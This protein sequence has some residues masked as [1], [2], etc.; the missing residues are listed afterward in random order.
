MTDLSSMTAPKLKDFFDA[1]LVRALASEMSR[2]DPGFDAAAFIAHGSDGLDRLELSARAWHLAEGLQKSL[3]QPFPR[4]ADVLVASLGPEIPP[5]GNNGLSPLRYMPHVFF[6]QKYGLDDFEAAMRAQYELTKRFSAES[7]IRAF[8]VR[9]PDRTYARLLEWARDENAH[10]RRLVSEGSRPRLPWAPRL[11]AFQIDP[12][13]VIVL[14]EL[15]KD[16]PERYVQRSVANNLNDIGKDHPDLAVELCRQWLAGASPGREW[17]VRHALR[18]LV[19][20]GHRGALQA[21][22]VDGKPEISVTGA[23]LAPRR[24]EIGG[25]LR[26]SFTVTSTAG[27]VQDL[28]VDY[29][30]HFVKAN[31]ETRPKV[32]KLRRM[33]LPPAARVDLSSIVS[34][35]DM[36]TRRHYP[37][38]HRIDV[39]IN[40]VAYPLAEFEVR[41]SPPGSSYSQP[42]R[43]N[44]QYR[45]PQRPAITPSTPK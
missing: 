27:T 20:K 39:L 33:A 41:R 17:I 32:F 38:R 37:G 28:L 40:G 31:G 21:L 12:R 25:A 11:R 3:P 10:V 34:F 30:V 23:R 44:R 24:V 8:L 14:L 15:L 7:S 4:A 5:T 35:E 45:K 2:A 26:F 1:S 42:Q 9:Y 19:K 22:G 6:V 29:A 18:S 43:L 16:D 13:P 36:T